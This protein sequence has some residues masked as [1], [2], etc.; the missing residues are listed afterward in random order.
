MKAPP[1]KYLLACYAELKDVVML[2]RLRLPPS[3]RSTV[4]P[5]NLLLHRP[6][7]LGAP[8]Y[9]FVEGVHRGSY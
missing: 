2:L 5:Q 1:N 9:T 8:I 6:G 4:R 3:P 7:V